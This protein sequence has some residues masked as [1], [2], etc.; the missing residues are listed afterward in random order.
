M[1][2]TRSLVPRL[3]H[4]ALVCAA[5]ATVYNGL[6]L[7]AFAEASLPKKCTATSPCGATTVQCRGNDTACCC[8]VGVG[9]WTCGCHSTDY[10]Q[11]P[12]QTPTPVSCNDGV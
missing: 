11:S 10:C 7:A 3:G 1:H 6:G 5:I 12:P 2:P 9:A 4:L 8:R